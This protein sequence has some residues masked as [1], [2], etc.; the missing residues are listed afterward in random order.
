V[1]VTNKKENLHPGEVAQLLAWVQGDA[2]MPKAVYDLVRT[3]RK[4][5]GEKSTAAI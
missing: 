2:A 5:E 3:F 1:A 4:A